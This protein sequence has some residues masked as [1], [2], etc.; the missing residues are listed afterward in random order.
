MCRTWSR[1][2]RTTQSSSRS[3]AQMAG[4]AARPPAVG[5]PGSS[6]DDPRV[7]CETFYRLTIPGSSIDGPA[8]AV[9]YAVPVGAAIV[10]FLVARAA[11]GR[12]RERTASVSGPEG[13]HC[14]LR[15]SDPEHEEDDQDHHPEED[16]LDASLI[17]EW[18]L[19]DHA[20]TS[21][22]ISPAPITPA[23]TK[24]AWLRP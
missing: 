23:R 21:S 17:E 22:R 20:P 15:D 18:Y 4:R 5:G 16:E 6:S 11:L 24:E 3:G 7:R 14:L 2:V 1:R 12:N 9:M 13:P 8:F 19:S 10:T